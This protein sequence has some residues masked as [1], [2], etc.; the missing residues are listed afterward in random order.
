MI[1]IIIFSIFPI[2]YFI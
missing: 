1:D 2:I